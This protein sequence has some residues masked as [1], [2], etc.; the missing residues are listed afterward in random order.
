MKS[1]TNVIT[2]PHI[3][4]NHVFV[5]SEGSL[6]CLHGPASSPYPEPHVTS[7]Q[8]QPCLSDKLCYGH[9]YIIRSHLI[10]GQ[11]VCS[12]QVFETHSMLSTSF[13]C[14]LHTPVIASSFILLQG[15][16]HCTVKG[17]VIPLQAQ[18]GPEGGQRYSST[19]P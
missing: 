17:K 19:L 1:A 8:L 4:E 12:L 14:V 11:V 18:C 15:N 9:R 10:L 5:E 13:P 6:A 3:Q 16:I 7:P 2:R